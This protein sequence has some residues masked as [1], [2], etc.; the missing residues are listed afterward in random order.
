MITRVEDDN[1]LYGIVIRI[2]RDD[3]GVTFYTPGHLSQQVGH[4]VQPKGKVIPAH[5]HN[6][7]SREILL[8]QEVLVIRDGR[9]RVDFYDDERSYLESYVL[10]AGDIVVLCGGCHGFEALEAVDM[11]EVKQGPYA[12][13]RDK[14]LIESVPRELVRIRDRVR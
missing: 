14:T 1:G 5:F 7:M 8:T 12:G 10:E 3:D 4:L 6:R 13:D 9:L 2:Q 11:I